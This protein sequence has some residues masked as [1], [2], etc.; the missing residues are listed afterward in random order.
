M[1]EEDRRPPGVVQQLVEYENEPGKPCA[2]T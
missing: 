1:L 2:A